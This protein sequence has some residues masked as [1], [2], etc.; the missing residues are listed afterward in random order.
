MACG[1]VGAD[2]KETKMRMCTGV[3]AHAMYTGMHVVRLDALNHGA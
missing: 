1:G 2:S 3:P